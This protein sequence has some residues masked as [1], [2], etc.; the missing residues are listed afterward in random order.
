MDKN[1]PT[2]GPVTEKMLQALKTLETA[3]QLYFDALVARGG[4]SYAEQTMESDSEKW[5][6]VADILNNEIADAVEVWAV[7]GSDQL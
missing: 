5:G 1:K 3:K 2:I 6:S 4:K 7:G